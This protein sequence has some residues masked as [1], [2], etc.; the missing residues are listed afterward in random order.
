MSAK[1]GVLAE[2]IRACINRNS[3]ENGSNTPDFILA[4]YLIRCLEAYDTA[5]A[6]RD[7]W[8]GIST[9]PGASGS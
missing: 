2:E 6:A 4:A 5:T 8:Y 1:D 9:R 3:A 7:Q